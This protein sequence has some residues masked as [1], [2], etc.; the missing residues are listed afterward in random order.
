[1]ESRLH[2]RIHAA[3]MR[4]KSATGKDNSSSYGSVP[5]SPDHLTDSSANGEPEF[6]KSTNENTA[7]DQEP[8]DQTGGIDK[9]NDEQKSVDTHL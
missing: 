5:P 8:C 4:I 9:S 1:M 3:N 6:F 2:F 7:Q